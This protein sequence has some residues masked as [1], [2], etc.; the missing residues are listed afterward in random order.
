M[1]TGG[2]PGWSWLGLKPL[3]DDARL[4]ALYINFLSGW[5]LDLE[6]AQLIRQHFR[7]PI[8]CDLHMKVRPCSRTGCARCGRCRTSREWCA[9]S[10]SCR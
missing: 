2:V 3:L 6:T 7:G 5:E 10:T 9:A 8:Y 4:D 1:L